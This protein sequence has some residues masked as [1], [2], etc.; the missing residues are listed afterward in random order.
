MLC[1]TL[2]AFSF[3]ELCRQIRTCCCGYADYKLGFWIRWIPTFADMTTH[4]GGVTPSLRE[5]VIEWF[6][7][8]S[9]ILFDYVAKCSF[10]VIDALTCRAFESCH[11]VVDCAG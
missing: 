6:R 4:L 10:R 9:W 11:C 7:N 2:L 5:C 1:D 3:A 8:E